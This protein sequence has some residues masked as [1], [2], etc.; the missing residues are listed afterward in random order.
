MDHHIVAEE[1]SQDLVALS[2]SSINFEISTHAGC[3]DLRQISANGFGTCLYM[4]HGQKIV[5][6][7]LPAVIDVASA[8]G[9]ETE[10]TDMSLTPDFFDVDYKLT[11]VV[12]NAGDFT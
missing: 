9:D 8:G 2:H 11:A 3:Y 12:L 10:S 6:F 4:E 1:L 7:R 5:A